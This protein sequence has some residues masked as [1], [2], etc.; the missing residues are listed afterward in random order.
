MAVRRTSWLTHSIDGYSLTGVVVTPSQHPAGAA[1]FLGR[2]RAS[3]EHP[4][5]Q[6]RRHSH[7]SRVAHLMAAPLPQP[8]AGDLGGHDGVPA[9][10][11]SE[12]GLSEAR[13][14]PTAAS[15]RHSSLLA[16]LSRGLCRSPG[17]SAGDSHPGRTYFNT[18]GFSKDVLITD[19]SHLSPALISDIQKSDPTCTSSQIRSHVS[20]LNDRGPWLSSSLQRSS[21]AAQRL[22]SRS[23]ALTIH[24]VT[25]PKSPISLTGSQES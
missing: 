19:G 25:A 10:G 3:T 15:G 17:R 5:E 24:R 20:R 2:L 11:L 8:I 6:A 4:G 7:L 1:P 9:E 12:T 23:L 22:A 18:A 14:S 13:L 21:S 16:D